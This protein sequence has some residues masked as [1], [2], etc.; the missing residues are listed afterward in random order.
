M[1]RQDKFWIQQGT[2]ASNFSCTLSQYPIYRKDI[3]TAVLDEGNAVKDFVVL[4]KRD[5]EIANT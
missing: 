3:N 2:A 5:V 1:A 4:V